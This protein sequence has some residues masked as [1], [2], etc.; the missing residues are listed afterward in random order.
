MS[1][2]DCVAFGK[3]FS[4]SGAWFPPASMKNSC[5]GKYILYLEGRVPV[6]GRGLGVEAGDSPG[7]RQK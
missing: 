2:A 1:Q 4:L 7:E 3:L 5:W 6:R